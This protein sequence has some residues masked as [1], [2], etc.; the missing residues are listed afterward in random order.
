[1]HDRE[2]TQDAHGMI[3]PA[4]PQEARIGPFRAGDLVAPDGCAVDRRLFVEDSVYRLEQ[5]R[6]FARCWLYVGHESELQGNG[7]FITTTMGEDPVIVVRDLA[8][9]LRAFL[10]SCSHRGAKVCRADKGVTKTFRC[11]YHSWTF[12]TE[13]QLI[14]VPRQSS[15]YGE[16]FDRSLLGLREVPHVDTIGGM[17]FACWDPAAPPLR[18]YLGDM[19]FYLDLM[20]T[21]MEGG[22]EAIGGVHKWTIDVNWKIPS[23]N[24]A[25]DHYHVPSTHGAGVE[26]GYRSPLTNNGY[27][28][29]TGNGHSIGSER[30]GAQQGKAVQTG[31]EDFMADMRAQ[32]VA[33]YGEAASAFTPIGVG[34]L[35]P[36][37]SFLDSARFRSFRVWHPRGVDKIEVYSWCI[38]DKAMPAELKAAVRKQYSLAFGPGGIFEQDDGDIWQSVQDALRGH[39]GRQGRFN[40]QMGLGREAP[41][42]QLYGPPFPGSCSDILM[43]E[44]N[45]RAFYRHYARL[46]TDK[47]A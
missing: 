4:V 14:S 43:T 16:G 46:M 9:R 8:G 36:N 2:T 7:A 41:T 35:F 31:Y 22:T 11:P 27:C 10:N 37:F 34:T 42:S 21:R 3:P 18:D 32:L 40:Y 15:V 39:V 44:A 23:E 25:G 29:Q 24:F 30:G 45:Q 33:R 1:M 12:S 20:L 26:M 19:T 5:E 38:V 17:I 47:E 13:G 6:I 28:I